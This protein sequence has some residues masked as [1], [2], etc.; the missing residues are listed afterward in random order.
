MNI[1]MPSLFVS[2]LEILFAEMLFLVTVI[3]LLYILFY[4]QLGVEWKVASDLL[5]QLEA[6]TCAMYGQARDTSV[7]V[8]RSKVLKK[9]VGEDS[10]LNAKSRVDM[11]RLPPCQDSLIPHIQRVNHRV[12]CYRRA[13]QPMFDR[14][15][16]YE[17]GQ[18]WQR[19]DEGVIEPVWSVGPI[20]PPSLLDLLATAVTDNG[21]HQQSEDAEP[22]PEEDTELDDDDILMV[23]ADDNS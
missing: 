16:P 17:E 13:A 18:G 20:L 7:N 1:I 3:L 11:V 21:N 12:A 5:K 2:I 19:T 14:P 8:V 4:R 6:F 9:M 10:T 23:D 22:H 15:K